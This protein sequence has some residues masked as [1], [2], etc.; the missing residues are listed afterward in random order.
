MPGPPPRRS[1]P[2]DR[3]CNRSIRRV[4]TILSAGTS[5]D[6]ACSQFHRRRCGLL[7]VQS[8]SAALFL[9]CL[10]PKPDMSCNS[11]FRNQWVVL[12]AFFLALLIFFLFVSFNSLQSQITLCYG[13]QVLLAAPFVAKHDL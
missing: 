7:A 6:R 13:H 10:S 12:D 4:V 9:G 5:R 11:L 3:F 8:A 2:N 1:Y